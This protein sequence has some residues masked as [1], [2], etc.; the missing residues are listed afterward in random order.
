M[1]YPAALGAM[2]GCGVAFTLGDLFKM[3]LAAIVSAVPAACLLSALSWLLSFVLPWIVPAF[4]APLIARERQLG[5][6]DLLRT[7]SL[8]GRSIVLGKLGGCALWLWPGLFTLA[9]LTP[10]R[11]TWM[12]GE[13]A[14][15]SLGLP[16][17][18]LAPQSG[19]DVERLWI[20]LLVAGCAGLLRPWSDL[21]FHA[22]AGLFVSVFARSVGVAL[23]ISYG[24]ILVA[25]TMFGLATSL[26]FPMLL[27]LNTPYWGQWR[28][29][30]TLALS[31]LSSLAV[32]VIEVIG[33]VLLV[34]AAIWCLERV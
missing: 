32:V 2:L 24:A 12:F 5:T 29:E 26:L 3:R 6:L 9:L 18:L 10:F 1:L 33:G 4:T 14:G 31:S 8:S 21:V 16:L 28:L 34:Q 23:A 17:A 11:M 27:V 19:L 15:T 7:T 22:A 30:Y 25:Q 20:W 13:V